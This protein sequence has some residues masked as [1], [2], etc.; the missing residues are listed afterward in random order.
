MKQRSPGVSDE[1]HK[2]FGGV[3]GSAPERATEDEKPR[4]QV[5]AP[6]PDSIWAEVSS[7]VEID[8]EVPEVP[9]W[10]KSS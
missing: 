7:I 3:H 5:V 9:R 8:A 2:G 4:E 1:S 10:R 6:D